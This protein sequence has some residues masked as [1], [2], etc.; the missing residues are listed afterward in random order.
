MAANAAAPLDVIPSPQLLPKKQ[1]LGQSLCFTCHIQL[2]F[3][4]K[5][6]KTDDKVLTVRENEP[7]Q[8]LLDKFFKAHDLLPSARVTMLFDGMTMTMTRTPASYD[9]EDEDLIDVTAKV[10]VFPLQVKT[11]NTTRAAGRRLAFT[12]RR[13]MGKNKVDEKVLQ[14]GQKETFQTLLESY[15]STTKVTRLQTI[16]FHYDG[17]TLDLQ[18]TLAQYDMQSED[19]I[20]VIIR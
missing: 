4:G 10:I 13:K 8:V 20:D 3:N 14:L 17:G 12:L 2:G 6:R 18:K 15:T 9:M 7:L 11:N 19:L 1:N 5:H 16:S